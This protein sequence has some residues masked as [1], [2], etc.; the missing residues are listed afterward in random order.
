LYE[1]KKKTGTKTHVFTVVDRDA[2]RL[3][4]RHLDL[5]SLFLRMLSLFFA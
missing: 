4:E 3:I 1:T 2:Q 5:G